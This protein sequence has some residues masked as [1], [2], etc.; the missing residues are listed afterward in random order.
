MSGGEI[1]P[2]PTGFETRY[3]HAGMR[4]ASCVGCGTTQSASFSRLITGPSVTVT[5]SSFVWLRL[6]R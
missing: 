6:H 4:G 5:G 1:E 2:N 3:L